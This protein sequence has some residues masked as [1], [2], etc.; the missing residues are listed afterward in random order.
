MIWWREF[1][2]LLIRIFFIIAKKCFLHTFSPSF[3]YVSYLVSDPPFLKISLQI[4]VCF[5]NCW[6][7]RLCFLQGVSYKSYCVYTC[8]LMIV[9]MRAWRRQ[10]IDGWLSVGCCQA[11]KERSVVR[12]GIEERPSPSPPPPPLPPPQWIGAAPNWF[13]EHGAVTILP[14]SEW[15]ATRP[16]RE[17]KDPARR[18]RPITTW[19]KQAG[20]QAAGPCTH[21]VGKP[22]HFLVGA[23]ETGLENLTS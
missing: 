20:R 2:Y 14:E 12:P 5:L 9:R 1:I 19:I 23:C 7:S 21:I 10:W 8:T 17:K 13:S 18:A 16:W 3:T 4:R 15:H 11:M 22:K 6:K